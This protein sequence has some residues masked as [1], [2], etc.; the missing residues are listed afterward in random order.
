MATYG[1]QFT[2]TKGISRVE[3]LLRRINEG[4]VDPLEADRIIPLDE[5]ER[6]SIDDV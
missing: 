4:L 2:L 6:L 3:H 1:G 5:D